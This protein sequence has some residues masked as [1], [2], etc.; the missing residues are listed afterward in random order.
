VPFIVDFFEGLG[1]DGDEEVEHYDVHD[2]E[3]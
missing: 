2:Q 1:D 3:H